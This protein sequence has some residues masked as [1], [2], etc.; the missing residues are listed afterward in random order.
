MSLSPNKI[1]ILSSVLSYEK[2]KGLSTF[3]KGMRSVSI[4]DILKRLIRWE[5]P[6]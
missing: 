1:F 2:E 4:Y 5:I 3:S 6:A